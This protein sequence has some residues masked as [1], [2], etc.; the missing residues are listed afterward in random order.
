MD[1]VDRGM[2]SFQ[3]LAGAVE[4][5][6]MG[7]WVAECVGEWRIGSLWRYPLTKNG[8]VP[9]GGLQNDVRTGRWT[10]YVR[11]SARSDRGEDT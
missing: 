1:A 4:T 9:H 11:L 2:K 10:S 8:N 5:R 6:R 7:I 3:E